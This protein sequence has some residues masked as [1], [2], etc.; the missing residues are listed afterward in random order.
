MKRMMANTILLLVVLAAQLGAPARAERWPQFFFAAFSFQNDRPLN[1]NQV[2][3]L[4]E[5]KIEDEIIAREIRKLGIAF[6]VDSAL[7]DRLLKLGAGTQTRQA[8]Q[9]WEE[10]AAYAEFSNEKNPARRLSLGKEFVQKHP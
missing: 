6:R 10:R 3:Q 9:H 4:L 2:E 5:S 1:L 7:L 8:L